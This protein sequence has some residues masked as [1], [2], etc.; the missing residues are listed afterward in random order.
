MREARNVMVMIVNES[1]LSISGT[2]KRKSFRT[3]KQ[4]QKQKRNGAD[5]GEGSAQGNIV[6]EER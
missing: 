2:P 4:K 6:H 1:C 5:G 3:Q